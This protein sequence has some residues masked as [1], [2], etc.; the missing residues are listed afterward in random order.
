M[1]KREIDGPTG[2]THVSASM[3]AGGHLVTTEV[4]VDADIAK[5][6]QMVAYQGE[7]HV[8]LRL[9]DGTTVYAITRQQL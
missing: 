5:R 8:E 9:M 7:H 3:W 2:K 6:L 1:M 4:V